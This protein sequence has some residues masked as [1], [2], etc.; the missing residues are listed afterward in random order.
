MSPADLLERSEARSARLLRR[1][2]KQLAAAYGPQAWWPASSPF[3]V[4]VGAYLT[5]NTSWRGVERSILN[6]KSH[7]SLSVE[8]IREIPEESL[9]ALIRP[10]GYMVRK[11]SAIKAFVGFLDGEYAGSLDALAAEELPIARPK[12]LALPGVG[13]ETADAILLYALGQPAMV[14][15]EYLRRIVTRHALLPERAKYKDMQALAELSLRPEEPETL[16]QHYNEFHA[17][18]VMVGK[19]HCGPTPKCEGCPLD[20][21]LD[22]ERTSAS[23]TRI[24]RS[25]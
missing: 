25:P 22:R 24:T 5:Q 2:Y 11:A 16:V 21:F 6:L 10:S 14:V 4:V 20:P 17:L 8:G 13:P 9:R 18:A 19:T 15:D 1:M 7:G 12:L 23:R 3:E